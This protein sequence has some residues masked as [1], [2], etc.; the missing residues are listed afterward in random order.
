MDLVISVYKL[1]EQ[2]PKEEIYYLTSHTRKTS[3]SIPLN[4][5]EGRKRYSKKEFI[6]F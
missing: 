3:I 6:N 4:I 1:T 2:Y 5:A